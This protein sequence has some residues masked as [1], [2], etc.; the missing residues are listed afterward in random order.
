MVFIEDFRLQGPFCPGQPLA[1]FDDACPLLGDLVFL[2]PQNQD[3]DQQLQTNRGDRD[4]EKEAVD[5][6]PVF[7]LRRPPFLGAGG[8]G[9]RTWR[10]AKGMR[11]VK[12]R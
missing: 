9:G 3:I 5:V 1:F 11:I 2:W 12:F 8:I 10:S 6:E 7:H 4:T